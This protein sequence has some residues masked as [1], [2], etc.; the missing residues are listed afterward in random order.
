M[1]LNFVMFIAN[2]TMISLR[3]Y[4]WPRTFKAS[5]LHPTESLFVPAFAISIGTIL[6]NICQYGLHPGKTGP[7]LVSTMVVFFWIYVA[8]AFLFSTGMYLLM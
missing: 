2:C 8:F 5:F 1:I 3:F 7:W 4:Y 6:L